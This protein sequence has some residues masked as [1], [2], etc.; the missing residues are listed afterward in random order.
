MIGMLELW[1]NDLNFPTDYIYI[2]TITYIHTYMHACMHTYTVYIYIYSP[3]LYFHLFASQSAG[4]TF[5]QFR[6]GGREGP[7]NQRLG[8][9]V[10]SRGAG[11]WR[12]F[13]RAMWGSPNSWMV[14]MENPNIPWVIYIGVARFWLRTPP[15]FFFFFWKIEVSRKWPCENRCRNWRPTKNWPGAQLGP[16]GRNVWMSPAE[17]I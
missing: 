1:Y 12:G 5:H 6:P 11:P 10:L 3:T 7:R 8:A 13:R 4:T 9:G 16:A 15:H 14:Y 2:C 17:P